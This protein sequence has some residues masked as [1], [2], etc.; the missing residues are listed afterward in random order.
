MKIKKKMINGIEVLLV[1]NHDV[2]YCYAMFE[3]DWYQFYLNNIDGD[4]KHLI[5]KIGLGKFIAKLRKQ[6][7]IN[8]HQSHRD[9]KIK[10]DS[11]ARGLDIADNCMQDA[12][13]SGHRFF[14]IAWRVT[15]QLEG[16]FTD[17]GYSFAEVIRGQYMS[18]YS[19]VMLVSHIGDKKYYE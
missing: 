10:L 2:V 8:F 11:Y 17:W 9:Y 5:D 13:K 6:Q 1:F 12:V 18:Q 3:G 14:N 19:D 7:Y 15:E 16:Y 4:Y